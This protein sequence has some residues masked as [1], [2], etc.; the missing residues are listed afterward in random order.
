MA[1]IGQKSVGQIG[2]LWTWT[3]ATT[4]VTSTLN[5]KATSASRIVSNK[6]VNYDNGTI[7]FAASNTGALGAA[8]QTSYLTISAG[9][10][11]CAPGL[12]WFVGTTPHVVQIN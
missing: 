3:S 2:D 6:V 1:D 8:T 10:S 4:S 9:T 11:A 7:Y 12:V 5:D